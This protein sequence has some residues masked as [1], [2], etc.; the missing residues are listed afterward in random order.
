[1]T[2]DILQ[3]AREALA[4]DAKATPG[5]WEWRMLVLYAP[6][7]EVPHAITAMDANAAWST[8]ADDSALI[9]AARTRELI[10]GSRGVFA[11]SQELFS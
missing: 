1:M 5:P 4:D 11:A 7:C 8:A 9:A 2:A 3:L 6:K 10:A